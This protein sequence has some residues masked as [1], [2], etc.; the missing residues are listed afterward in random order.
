[1]YGKGGVK[2]ED[3]LNGTLISQRKTQTVLEIAERPG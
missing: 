3:K 2:A 1:M